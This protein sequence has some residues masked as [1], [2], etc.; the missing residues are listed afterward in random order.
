MKIAGLSPDAVLFSGFVWLIMMLFLCGV[1]IPAGRGTVAVRATAPR[2]SNGAF[3]SVSI[4]ELS[5]SPVFS[6][7]QMYIFSISQ[8]SFH[9]PAIYAMHWWHPILQLPCSGGWIRTIDIKGMDLASWPLLYPAP[10]LPSCLPRPLEVKAFGQV[11]CEAKY[12]C[13]LGGAIR[14]GKDY[15]GTHKPGRV[16]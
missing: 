5:A 7:C 11:L 12:A 1:G 4:V 2:L 3:V 14:N 16:Y 6:W 9:Q 13:G 8:M 15:G 10:I